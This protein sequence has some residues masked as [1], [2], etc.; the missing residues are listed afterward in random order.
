M[1]QLLI[2][3]NN[4]NKIR[5]FKEILAN[6]PFKLLTCADL[7]AHLDIE[8]TG[9]T[10]RENALIKAK[11]FYDR[12]RI[13]TIADD[14]GLEVIALGNRPGVFSQRYSPSGTD[15][16]NLALLLKEMHGVED[17]RAQY[18]CELVY[19]QSPETVVFFSGILK[20]QIMDNPI[21]G[22]GFGYD[23]VFYIPSLKKRLSQ[24]RP[25][26]KNAIS[27]RGQAIRQLLDL[28][29]SHS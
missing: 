29:R 16:D 22:N 19:Y 14:S 26:E 4:F 2:A 5:E 18:V 3:S 8:E 17:R 7:N 1:K 12:F 9:M 15:E 11:A 25:E 24:C 23:P 20:G 6:S 27:H 13:P 21:S 10:F 28:L